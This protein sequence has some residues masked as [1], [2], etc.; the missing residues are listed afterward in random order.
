[1]FKRI[2]YSLQ[3]GIVDYRQLG[4]SNLK[5]S[6][7]GFG[8]WAAGA[9]G[10][11]DVRDNESIAAIRQ[12]MD[13]GINFF[14]TADVYGR[15]HSEE[16]LARALGNRRKE[17]I[18]A[19][20][21]GNRWSADGTRIWADLSPKYIRRAVEDSLRRLK[22]DVIDLYQIHRPD[23]QTPVVE[24]M[25][26]LLDLV[27]EGKIRYI[28]TSNLSPDQLREYISY[29]QVVSLQPVLNLF[30]RY[31][32]V[33]LLPLC[34]EKTVGVVVYSPMAMGLLTGKY[35]KPVSFKPGDF[36]TMNVLF[37]GKNFERN[38]TVVK[39]LK[40]F[41]NER[42]Y[43]VAQLAVA[44]VIAHPAVT[45]AICGAK[46]PGQIKETAGSFAW[47]LTHDELIEIDRIVASAA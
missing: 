44:W 31:S 1:M 11:G 2:F 14:D 8:C 41:A 32:E 21:V 45:S 47:K 18:I 10:W 39:A 26:T 12:A 16:V 37:Q 36:R 28:G 5:L 29:G 19:T 38:I 17:V 34:R 22:T 42:G 30:T 4:T 25:A 20:K 27:K 46:R 7:I 24:T 43:S 13:L 33:Q 9:Y 15:G 40:K 35:N 23:P 3:E 6:V